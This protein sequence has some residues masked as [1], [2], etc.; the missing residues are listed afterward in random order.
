MLRMLSMLH[1]LRVLALSSQDRLIHIRMLSMLHML[2]VLGR[3]M[4]LFNQLPSE[5][6]LR[7]WDLLLFEGSKTLFRTSLAL[8]VLQRLLSYAHVC[9]RMLTYADVC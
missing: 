3:F 6:M 1:M 2:R 5:S 9:S 7:V 4:C 8:L